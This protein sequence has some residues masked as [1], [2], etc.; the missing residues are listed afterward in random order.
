MKY[1][2]M[3]VKESLGGSDWGHSR[4]RRAGTALSR[5]RHAGEIPISLKIS[6]KK[7]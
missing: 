6:T 1:C 3:V 7:Q 4:E 2:S 5:A